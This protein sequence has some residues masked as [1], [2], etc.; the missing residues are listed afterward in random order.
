MERKERQEE[1]WSIKQLPG[2]GRQLLLAAFIFF[3]LLGASQ[4]GQGMAIDVVSFAKNTVNSDLSWDE[5]KAWVSNLPQ[6]IQN[7]SNLNLKDFWAK[8]V[9]G[10]AQEPAWPVMGKIT[11]YYGW[12]PNPDSEGM[13]LHQG[14]DIA[15]EVGT[16]VKAALDGM[17]ISV[18]QSADFGLVVEVEHGGGL[19][20]VYAH[21]DSASVKENQKVK[22]GNTLGTVGEG[23]NATGPHLHFE[24]RKDGLEIDPLTIMPVPN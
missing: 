16:D 19:S 10:K 9:S 6:G 21:L 20:T 8:A 23:G 12:R 17:V 24:L 2:W 1:S 4:A 11:S 5:V 13:S 3:A 22:K 18:R 7:F 15:A 14:I